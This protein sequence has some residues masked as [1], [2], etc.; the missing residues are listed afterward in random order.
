MWIMWR[1][2]CSGGGFRAPTA[3]AIERVHGMGKPKIDRGAALSHAMRPYGS[4]C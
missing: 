1:G 4:V 2:S 3:I